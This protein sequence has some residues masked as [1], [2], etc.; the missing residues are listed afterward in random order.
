MKFR[1]V[2]LA[3]AAASCAVAS[4]HA[5]A[6]DKVK[7]EFWSNSL[8]PKF[9]AVMKDLT[10]KFNAANPDIEAV[11]S[12]VDWD[13]FQPRF[14]AAL[15]A[16]NAPD[17]VNLPV[18]WAAE[19]AQ[20]GL[21]LPLDSKIGGF[22]KVYTDAA[23]KDVTYGGKI[24]GL[25]WY[26]SVSIIAYNKALFDKAGL[27]AAPKSLDELFA[28]SKQ[29]KDKTGVSGFAP[30]LQEFSS[31]F[32]YEGLPVI[33]NG[34]AVF[35][36]PEHV[37][38]VERFAQAY[39]DGSIPK[40]VFKM[41]FE[42]EIAAYD[43]GKIAMMTTSPQALKRTQTDAKPIYAQ[44][45]TTSFPLSNGKTPFGGYLFFWSVPK[46]SK[47]ADAA[48]KLGQFLTNDANQLAFS[49]ATETTFPSTRNAV[50][51]AYFQSG[52]NSTDPIEHGRAVAALAI[53]DTRTLTVTGLPDEASMNKKLQDELQEAIAGRKP[54]KQA[55]DETVAFWNSKLGAK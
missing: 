3:L 24:Y 9:D 15:A 31:W 13:A 34:K 50:G 6:A 41:E 21:L 49:K 54:V 47:H 39:K 22:K 26:N 11:W 36:S 48:I 10:A 7:V 25:P 4:L 30:K 53:R 28:Y 27:K 51:D 44:T 19:Y 29:L 12:D 1:K 8:S 37:K 40:D 23:I 33:Q 16:G 45:V 2:V 52:A 32:M 20:K 55:L 35:N 14:V 43:S 38:F 42:Q 17:L 46:G 18:P 5:T